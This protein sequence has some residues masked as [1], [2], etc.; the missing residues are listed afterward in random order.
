MAAAAAAAGGGGSGR[1]GGSAAAAGLPPA[2]ASAACRAMRA[3]GAKLDLSDET[4]A[5]AA[6]FFHRFF[7]A[8]SPAKFRRDTM[9]M[10][11]LFLAAKANEQ[12]RKARDVINV[13][14]A[15][16]DAGSGAQPMQIS[17]RFWDKK[18]LLV[19][20]E[21][22]LLRALAFDVEV[23]LPHRFLLNY[24]RSLR[25]PRALVQVAWGFVNDS[26]ESA[27]ASLR[28]E[29]HAVACAA[30]QLAAALLQVELP[31]GGSGAAGADAAL[32]AA[33]GRP[34]HEAFGVSA[35]ALA[36]AANRIATVYPPE[37]KGV[38]VASPGAAGG[39]GA[40]KRPRLSGANT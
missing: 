35:Q 10:A 15:I 28:T 29:P 24:A 19:E 32:G 6:V 40:A 12:Q 21:S 14:N 8:H 36:V 3:A 22:Y 34:W 23:A 7:A 31:A 18:D 26:F 30:V 37:E 13:F 39:D 5:T 20:Y 2:E 17:Q 9:T 16:A 4:V 38:A 11:C 1:G 25:A 27:E 33:A